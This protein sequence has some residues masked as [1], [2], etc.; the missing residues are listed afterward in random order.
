M[1]SIEEHVTPER[2]RARWDHWFVT[3][4]ASSPRPGNTCPGMLVFAAFVDSCPKG[5]DVDTLAGAHRLAHELRWDGA[6]SSIPAW[7]TEFSEGFREATTDFGYRMELGRVDAGLSVAGTFV[8]NTDRVF[9]FRL[10]RFLVLEPPSVRLREQTW[11]QH[12]APL[13]NAFATQIAYCLPTTPL[14]PDCGVW[15]EPKRRAEVQLIHQADFQLSQ[16]SDTPR[17][18]VTVRYQG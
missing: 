17:I 6:E 11:D 1:W 7:M 8:T 12:I 16:V 13:R 3:R 9:V 15:I 10:G 4:V 2:A 18:R 5:F 14:T